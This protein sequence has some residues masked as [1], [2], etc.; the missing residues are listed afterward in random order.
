MKAGDEMRIKNYNTR[1]Y[2]YMKEKKWLVKKTVILPY[3]PTF[4]PKNANGMLY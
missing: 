3:L 1:I 2:K 4:L